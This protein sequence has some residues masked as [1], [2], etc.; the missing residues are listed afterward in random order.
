M[1]R[2]DYDDSAIDT[3]SIGKI[4]TLYEGHINDDIEI[5]VSSAPFNVTAKSDNHTVTVDI[6]ES[7]KT[8]TAKLAVYLLLKEMTGISLP[9]GDM[10]G[11][12]PLKKFAQISATQGLSVAQHFFKNSYAV[13][14]EKIAL[15]S[16]TM[17]HQTNRYFPK[18]NTA[19]LYVHIPLCVSKCTYCSFPSRIT[20]IGQHV[21]RRIS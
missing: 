9:W 17:L 15:L 20:T 18:E 8:K 10:T 2:I 5:R 21:M 16:E 3:V 19:D 13:S 7:S 11:V 4:V 6:I 1:I 14:E 12:K